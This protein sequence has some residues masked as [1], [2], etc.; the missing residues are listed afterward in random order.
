MSEIFLQGFFCQKAVHWLRQFQQQFSDFRG[1]G[2]WMFLQQKGGG[3]ADERCGHGSTAHADVM[4]A[5]HILWAAAGQGKIIIGGK[6]GNDIIPRSPEVGAEEFFFCETGKRRGGKTGAVFPSPGGDD[7]VAD[8]WR[9]AVAPVFIGISCGGHHHDARFPQFFGG[10]LQRRISPAVIGTDGKIHHA[11]VVL[12]GVLQNPAQGPHCLYG[13]TL[14]A[15]VQD[16][17]G[18]DISMGHD[19]VVNAAGK[20]AVS[21]GNTSDMADG[22]E[23]QEFVA[24]CV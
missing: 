17:D 1:S 8:R 21:T 7:A 16:F 23:N 10:F 11:D 6:D 20:G 14:S 22:S 24:I 18:N 9:R 12:S 2:L 5:D 3:A 4:S 13:I 15:A 19:S